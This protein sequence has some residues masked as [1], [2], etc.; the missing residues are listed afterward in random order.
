MSAWNGLRDEKDYTEKRTNVAAHNEN[1]HVFG[2]GRRTRQAVE[3]REEPGLLW[4]HRC[5]P[6]VGPATA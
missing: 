6:A 1:V 2:D 4:R 5:C 3:Q